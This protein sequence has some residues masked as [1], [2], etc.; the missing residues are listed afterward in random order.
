MIAASDVKKVL[1]P[2][3]WPRGVKGRKWYEPR[4]EVN[5]M[6]D[7]RAVGEQQ[8]DEEEETLVKTV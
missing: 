5:R 1:D 6:R 4:E 2:A 7:D 3:F 8:I